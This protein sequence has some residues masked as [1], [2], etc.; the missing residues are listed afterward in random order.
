MAFHKASWDGTPIDALARV[1]GLEIAAMTGFILGAGSRGIPVVVDGFIASAAAL[2][3]LRINPCVRNYCIFSHAS[4][5][6]FHKQFLAAEQI[7]P[8]LD[9]GLRL[10]EGTGAVLAM[11]IVKQALACY[12]EMATFSS[13]GVSGENA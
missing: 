5:E 10:G 2:V 12:N 6:A 8:V 1:G 13:A 3:A 11:Q 4:A 7:T 9:L